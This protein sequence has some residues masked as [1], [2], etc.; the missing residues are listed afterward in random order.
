[1]L[2]P[3]PV[4]RALQVVA[5]DRTSGAQE[6]ARRA[7]SAITEMLATSRVDSPEE[8]IDLTRICAAALARS[9]PAMSAIGNVAA[10]LFV[11]ASE[12]IKNSSEPRAAAERAASELLAEMDR[13]LAQ[14]V[15]RTA[16]AVPV[17]SIV[18][19]LSFSR[20]VLDGL[21]GAKP[22]QVIVAESRP[23]LEGR[24]TARA[25]M[26]I[27]HKVALV[28][29]AAAPGLARDVDLV[30]IGADAV[31]ADGAVVNKVGSYPIALAASAAGVP[32][33]ATCQSFKITPMHSMPPEVHDGLELWETS[34]EGLEIRNPYFELVPR[35]LISGIVIETGVIE[36]DEAAR[37]AAA[38]RFALKAIGI[39]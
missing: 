31:L 32:V 27:G 29:D 36:C 20:T 4:Q 39:S 18:M 33:Y 34:P 26:E 12:A 3:P 35:D 17:G 14:T 2:L 1:M 11:R 10:E 37:L 7:A 16:D 23:A 30:L 21:T 13:A 19:T 24:E 28:S 15:G 8:L 5:D 38:R 25:L 22:A 9:R 6:L